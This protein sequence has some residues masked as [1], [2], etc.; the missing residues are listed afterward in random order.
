MVCVRS[1]MHLADRSATLPQR[2]RLTRADGGSVI[3]S[4]HVCANGV[5]RA[6]CPR[7]DPLAI[8]RFHHVAQRST[9]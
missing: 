5:T 3:A 7:R 8:L 4:G 6:H 9:Q 1:Q 2:V